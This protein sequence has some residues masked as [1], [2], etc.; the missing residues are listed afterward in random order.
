MKRNDPSPTVTWRRRSAGF[1]SSSEIR[2]GSRYSR[3]AVCRDTAYSF[4]P[5]KYFKLA[6]I[7]CNGAGVSSSM[8]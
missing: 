7:A 2:V 4:S 6:G 1:N 5:F 3:E 8:M